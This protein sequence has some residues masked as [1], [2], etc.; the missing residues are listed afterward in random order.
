MKFMLVCGWPT[1]YKN[2]FGIHLPHV[3]WQVHVRVK[4]QLA[5]CSGGESLYAEL[6]ASD[7]RDTCGF[8]Y[9]PNLTPTVLH[10]SPTSATNGDT[11]QINGTGFSANVTDNFVRFGGIDCNITSSSEELIECTLGVGVA[12]NH[13]LHLHV[14]PNSVASTKGVELQYKVEVDSISVT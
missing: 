10:I 9:T 13:I 12:G 2:N 6:T 11:I 8:T 1:T 5:A 3:L 7:Y 4:G 14:L